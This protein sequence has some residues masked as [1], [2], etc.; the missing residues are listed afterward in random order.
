MLEDRGACG[1]DPLTG[2]P[3]VV[4]L[5][6][7][8]NHR[9]RRRGSRQG[10]VPGSYDTPATRQRRYTPS[11]TAK[12]GSYAAGSDNIEERIPICDLMEMHMVDSNSMNLC[13][14]LGK[15]PKDCHGLDSCPLRQ[16]CSADA[17]YKR[18]KRRLLA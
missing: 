12:C 11:C 16:L 10:A 4:P 14:C 18:R 5:E 3:V 1:R 15:N 17:G 2:N 8:Q 9:R 6:P 7:F 13:F